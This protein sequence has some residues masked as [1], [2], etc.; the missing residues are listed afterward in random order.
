[1]VDRDWITIYKKQIGAEYRLDNTHYIEYTYQ[2]FKDELNKSNI[3]ILSHYVQFGEL[4]A[5]CKAG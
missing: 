1:M 2:Q 5:V 3:E 4:Y